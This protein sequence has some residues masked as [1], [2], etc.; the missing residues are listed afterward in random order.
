MYLTGFL[1]DSASN[2][3]LQWQILNR[4]GYI[5]LYGTPNRG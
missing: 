4:T 2:V 5:C 3:L 1:S